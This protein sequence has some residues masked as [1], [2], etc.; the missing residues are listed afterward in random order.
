MAGQLLTPRE[1]EYLLWALRGKTAWETA[2]IL[3]TSEH[4]A[5][6]MLQSAMR[7]LGA[8]N[9]QVAAL[10]AFELGLLPIGSEES[11]TEGAELGALL[12]RR[13]SSGDR[14][15]VT[16]WRPVM[17]RSEDLLTL[18]F[19]PLSIW[20]TSEQHKIS[21]VLYVTARTGSTI[22]QSRVDGQDD[23]G[24]RWDWYESEGIVAA[25]NLLEIESNLAL[26]DSRGAKALQNVTLSLAAIVTR[27]NWQDEILSFLKA[28]T[29]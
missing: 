8:P 17:L 20:Q 22:W 28:S 13:R 7:K 9:K 29:G 10:K 1:T 15:D 26:V 25:V 5:A 23:I 3:K 4:T 24:V 16:A 19:K 27:L 12:R 18:E 6:K 11:S 2:A 21:T 14:R